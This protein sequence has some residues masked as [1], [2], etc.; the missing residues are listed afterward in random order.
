MARIAVG[1]MQ[2][3]TNTFAPSRA[4]Y[5]AFEAGGGWPGVQYGEP[6]F[7]AV[8]G[9]NIPAAG[10]IEALRARGHQLVATAWGAASPSAHVTT[11]AFERIV[12]ELISHL[13]KALPVDGV[14]LDLH[15]AMVT[16][17]HDDGEGEI[18]R[19]VREVVGP[20][21]PVSASLDLHCNFTH[22]MFDNCDALVA[23]R[24]Y[25]HVDMADTGA[26]AA[27][28][29]DRMVRSGQPLAKH[30]RAL[31]YLTGLPSQCS[32][33]D[34]CKAIYEDLGREGETTLSFTPGFPMADFAECG[35]AVFGYGVD[36]KRT[37]AAVDR[38]HAAVA[39]AEKDFALELHLP[40]EAVARAR[41]RGE[42]GRP[43]VLADT[44]DNPGAGG[45]G[46]TTGLLKSLIQQKA[47]DAV[48]GLL[49]DGEAA[50]KAHEAGQGATLVFSLGGKSN[51]SG[52]SPCV[53]EFTVEQLG[54]GKF[55][56]TGP[57]FKGFRMQLGSMA[58]LRSKAAPG[59][60]VALA[61]RKCQAGD[62]EMF[63]HLGV[64]PRRSRI[65]AL[66]SSVHFRADF[67]PIA[68]EVVVVK[69]PGPALADPTEFAWTRLR[70]GLRLRPLGPAFQG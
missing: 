16:E 4:D 51:I 24:T 19:R 53:G 22:A 68:K 28:L 58:L 3:E 26:R 33:I 59:V 66:K 34:P 23:Y 69:S 29:L 9:A 62:Q 52:D 18:L 65:L 38:L 8:A 6:V 31:D 45:N 35:M 12:G 2:H 5:G 67:E 64:E 20:R 41:S 17:A 49:I 13:K 54:D 55:T 50:K 56:C 25:P 48:L 60:R 37:S 70:K 39:D 42:P 11:D 61:S 21:V 10:A 1:G 27:A 15:G 32:F 14:Y 46:D 36:A 30:W 7:A 63:R 43:V 40:D 57:M 44:Q 47:Q